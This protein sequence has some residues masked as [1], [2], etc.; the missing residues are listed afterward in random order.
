MEN[1]TASGN[2][3]LTS[4]PIGAHNLTVYAAD[5]GGNTVASETIFFDVEFLDFL[6]VAAV[7]IVTVAI[8]ILGLALHLKKR[9]NNPSFE[10]NT[11][12]YCCESNS[13]VE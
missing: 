6:P 4:L 12:K 2:I 9:R 1:H 5:L 10:E 11:P 8:A 13:P 3:T 7:T